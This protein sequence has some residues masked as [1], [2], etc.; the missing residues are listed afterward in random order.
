[1][2]YSGGEVVA[3]QEDP[4]EAQNRNVPTGGTNQPPKLEG[5]PPSE[6]VLRL[7]EAMD[8]QV[9]FDTPEDKAS[10]VAVW[11][12]QL[13]RMGFVPKQARKLAYTKLLIS[14]GE[15]AD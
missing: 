1:V 8:L 13:V 6:E 2:T 10:H 4:N 9:G 14:T 5:V 15:L 12:R 3:T 11:E 7:E